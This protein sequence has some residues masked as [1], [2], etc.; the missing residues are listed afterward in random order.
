[1]TTPTT[2][3]LASQ[4]APTYIG[5][6]AEYQRH[7]ARGLRVRGVEAC[8]LCEY[9]RHPDDRLGYETLP[10]PLHIL[11]ESLPGQMTQSWLPRLSTRA[12]QWAAWLAGRRLIMPR[13]LSP[14][15]I[16]VTGTGWDHT[17][18]AM[19]RWAHK[20]GV[21]LSVWPAVHP[22]QWGDAPIDLE[23]YRRADV[24]FCQSGSEQDHLARLG[25]PPEKTRI[26]GLPPFCLP[27]GDGARLRD[28]LGIGRRPT[29]LFLGRRDAG[30][31]YPALLEAWKLVLPRHPEAVLLVAGPG[32]PLREKTL[33]AES[34]RDLGLVDERTKAD[35]Y[36]ACDV[37]C[38][39]SAHESFGIVYVEAWSYGKPVICGTAPASRELV[40]DGKTGL[41][42][43]QDP[44]VLAEKIHNLLDAPAL[45]ANL[46]AEGSRLQRERYTTEAMVAAHLR[47]WQQVAA[48]R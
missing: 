37:F 40:E 4:I 44:S 29:V 46:G 32:E 8:S 15:A 33:P 2:I 48:S 21:P 36:A 6:L 47:A 17:G 24:V 30:K 38:L 42:A 14:S 1:M 9:E 41:W 20:L 11:K 34:Y 7:L 27:D 31:G 5:G 43:A 22:G 39:P 19:V 10:W 28:Q 18:F 35:A 12:P 25:L 23:L 3:A 13:A 16:H 26:C 45:A